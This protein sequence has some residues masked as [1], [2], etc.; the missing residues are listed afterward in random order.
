METAILSHDGLPGIRVAVLDCLG[1]TEVGSQQ[2]IAGISKLNNFRFS[3]GGVKVWQAFDI[4]PGKDIR[5]EEANGTFPFV[6][7]IF[8]CKAEYTYCEEVLRSGVT[9]VRSNGA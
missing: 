9:T 3:P 2:K 5:L 1:E 8:L 7:F 6:N 4:G